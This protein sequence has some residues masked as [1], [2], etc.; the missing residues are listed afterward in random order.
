MGEN[1]TLITH[2]PPAATDAGHVVAVKGPVVLT[3]VTVKAVDWLFV[4]VA[5]WAA[6][7][8]PTVWLENSNEVGYK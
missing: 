2:V 8:V 1:V 4:N 3:L 5:V 6:L 7:V